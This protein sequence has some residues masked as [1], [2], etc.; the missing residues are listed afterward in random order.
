MPQRAHQE[1]NW[2]YNYQPIAEDQ[3]G[4]DEYDLSSFGNDGHS[5]NSTVKMNV[6]MDH[7]GYDFD[8]PEIGSFTSPQRGPQPF[9]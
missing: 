8:Q 1:S 3:A 4:E 5:T 7:F 2:N 9:T 6:S